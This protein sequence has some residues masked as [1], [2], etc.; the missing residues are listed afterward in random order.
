MRERAK[1]MV[2]ASFAGDSL[3]LGAHW[4][5]DIDEIERRFGRVQTLLKPASGSYHPTKNAGELTHYGDQT[6][7]LLESI[8]E[9]GGFDL[10]K[11]SL[12]W[13]KMFSA[14][15][16]YF[17]HATKGTLQ[18]F[19]Q[20][21]TPADSGS[22][23]TDLAGAARI[24]PL[25]YRYRENPETLLQT[26]TAQTAM[27]HNSPAVLQ[28]AEFLAKV[29]S[30]VLAGS[31]PKESMARLAD[32]LYKGG[33]I[34]GS[35]H[36]ALE[37]LSSSTKEAVL[38]FGQSCNTKGA[39]PAVVHLVLK[40]ETDLREALVENVM[41]GGDSAARGLAVGMILGAH[42]GMGSIPEEWASGMKD[43]RKI[44]DLLSRIDEAA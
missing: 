6:M 44:L 17:D 18:N 39:L 19:D 40:Y 35:V 5:Y 7:V 37:T 38:E 2:L 34:A 26:V 27:T 43:H 32:G 13:R 9:E 10:E 21:R 16:G 3:A 15:G 4:I 8:A 24:A 22:P 14:Y 41:A 11:F 31:T 28:S 20:G 29:A 12:R 36:E 30:E 23:S 1:A 33:P 25:V 42:L